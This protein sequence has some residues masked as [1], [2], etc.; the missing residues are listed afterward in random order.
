M[1][2]L[3]FVSSTCVHC[4]KAEKLAKQVLPEYYSQGVSFKKIRIKTSEGKSLSSKF[5]VRGVPT[6]IFLSSDGSVLDRIVGVPREETLRHTVGKYSKGKS[7]EK[8]SF[9][10]KLLGR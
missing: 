6:F 3:L 1:Q 2:I 8:K 4:P 10:N 5:G 7:T 9:L